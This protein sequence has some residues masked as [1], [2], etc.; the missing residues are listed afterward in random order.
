MC[1]DDSPRVTRRRRRFLSPLRVF[2]RL[3]LITII[4]L[5]SRVYQPA[6]LDDARSLREHHARAISCTPVAP[7]MP[8]GNSHKIP[9][10]II[11]YGT[12]SYLDHCHARAFKSYWALK[13]SPS[14]R[15]GS[16]PA[17]VIRP[18]KSARTP[19]YSF[20]K[21]MLLVLFSRIRPRPLS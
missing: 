11:P 21:S 17:S 10:R 6:Q 5:F 18:Y 2:T 8:R 4:S 9:A 12:P 3:E 20:G 16:M 13:K 15:T 19:W 14:P 7:M 1:R